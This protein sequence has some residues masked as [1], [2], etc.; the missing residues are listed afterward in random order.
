MS[1][2]FGKAS[3]SLPQAAA[4]PPKAPSAPEP[5]DGL[6]C[7][8]AENICGNII[9]LC[10]YRQRLSSPGRP[11]CCHTSY[12]LCCRA[13]AYRTRIG[14]SFP[15]VCT[16]AAWEPHA[17]PASRFT[18]P[19]PCAAASTAAAAASAGAASA[20]LCNGTLLAVWRSLA[21]APCFVFLRNALSHQIAHHAASMGRG[22]PNDF[23]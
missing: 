9:M 18:H 17:A 1:L 2:A 19:P 12:P 7:R 20:L 15:E 4:A 21:R 8:E 5:H 11:S 14:V 23:I 3:Y 6:G 13:A 16:L 22:V 10:C